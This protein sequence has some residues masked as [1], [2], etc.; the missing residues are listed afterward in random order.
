MITDASSQKYRYVVVSVSVQKAF[1]RQFDASGAETDVVSVQ[2][3]KV[4][5]GFLNSS[6]KV[7]TGFTL[8]TADCSQFLQ[9]VNSLDYGAESF[10]MSKCAHML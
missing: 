3:Q 10:R 2:T 9:I 8:P 4:R 5:T 1:Q 6:Y 7:R